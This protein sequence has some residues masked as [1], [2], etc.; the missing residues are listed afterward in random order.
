MCIHNRQ[1]SDHSSHRTSFAIEQLYPPLY[2]GFQAYQEHNG[3]HYIASGPSGPGP[4][5]AV[6]VWESVPPTKDRGVNVPQDVICRYDL[7]EYLNSVSKVS[8]TTRCMYWQC[9]S[10]PQ[11]F[12]LPPHIK[13]WAPL[14]FGIVIGCLLS[15]IA[16]LLYTMSNSLFGSFIWLLEVRIIVLSRAGT[17]GD[18]G[19]V[20]RFS[21][22]FWTRYGR[23][24]SRTP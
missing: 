17:T 16:I 12:A 22:V 20:C 9:K 4:Q 1:R 8:L 23:N 24:L 15:V 6:K 13:R 11:T 18:D 10:S 3:R 7:S 2:R 5:F 14:F 19:P 21:A